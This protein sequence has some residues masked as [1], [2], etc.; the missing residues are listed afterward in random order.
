MLPGPDSFS[1]EKMDPEA[2]QGISP[3]PPGI[4]MNSSR[5]MDN[6]L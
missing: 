1:I 5:Q 3:P 4:N 6:S 2:A